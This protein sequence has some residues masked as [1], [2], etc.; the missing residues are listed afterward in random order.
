M[1][2]ALNPKRLFTL[3]NCGVFFFFFLASLECNQLLTGTVD[4]K[5][6]TF[7]PL[8]QTKH[9]NNVEVTAP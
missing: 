2:K 6:L 1:M 3:M 5:I 9:V 4:E 8:C 7:Y